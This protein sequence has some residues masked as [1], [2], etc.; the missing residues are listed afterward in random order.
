M[1]RSPAAAPRGGGPDV[2]TD[3]ERTALIEYLKTL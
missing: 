2:L 3:A 1:R